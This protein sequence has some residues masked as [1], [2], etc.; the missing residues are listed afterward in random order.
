MYIP[1]PT[2]IRSNR[3]EALIDR[4]VEGYCDGCD[5]PVKYELV[6]AGPMGDGPALCAECYPE[7]HGTV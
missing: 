4:H 1:D 2:E 7:G 5:K 3:I 6:C